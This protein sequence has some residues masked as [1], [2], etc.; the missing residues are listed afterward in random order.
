MNRKRLERNGYTTTD[1]VA[2]L[3]GKALRVY[4]HYCRTLRARFGDRH[5]EAKR[6]ISEEVLER[7]GHREHFGEQLVTA[8]LR[9]PAACLHVYPQFQD[10]QVNN[11][12][13]TVQTT[14]GRREETNSPYRLTRFHMFEVVCLGTDDYIEDRKD[15]LTQRCLD[16]VNEVQLPGAL[17]H[18]TDSFVPSS[19]GARILQRLKGLKQEYI[20]AETDTALFSIN[21]HER[22]FG[23][24][25]N[26]THS[27][28]EYVATLCIAFGLER[29]TATSLQAWGED[30]ENWPEGFRR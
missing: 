11:T 20:A 16:L 9:T 3:T 7:S 28:Q 23:K 4:E 8:P 14:C 2:E 25:F 13:C 22:H 12:T 24:N 21:M 29:I 15:V 18:A 30:E 5:I 27:T 1:G 10:S 19:E 26:I 17:Q 6:T